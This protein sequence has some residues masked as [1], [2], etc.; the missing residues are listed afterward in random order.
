MKTTLRAPRKTSVRPRFQST[1]RFLYR[2]LIYP[3]QVPTLKEPRFK[4]HE[5]CGNY[6]LKMLSNN[7]EL[8]QALQLRKRVFIGEVQNKTSTKPLEFDRFDGLADHLG[9]FD[10][11]ND[12]MI[13]TYRIFYSDEMQRFYSETEF[14]LESIHQLQGKKIE[15]GRACIHPNHRNGVVLQLLWKGIAKVMNLYGARYLLGCSSVHTTNPE[16][17]LALTSY[18][19]KNDMTLHQDDI[20]PLGEPWGGLADSSRMRNVSASETALAHLPPLLRMYLKAG[21]KV[22]QT[23]AF[24]K[25]FGCFDFFTIL[26]RE[27]LSVSFQKRFFS[28]D[29]T[30]KAFARPTDTRY[31]SCA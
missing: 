27:S 13:G 10:K 1:L 29:S 5:D 30:D 9:V 20:Y 14:N 15:L 22:A 25:D 3:L 18:F 28:H 31:S 24:D 19:Y 4:I 17:A 8:Y 23:P 2:N 7:K 12:R 16:V 6:S 21:A 26:D 11:N